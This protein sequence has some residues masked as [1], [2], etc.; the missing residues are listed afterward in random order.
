VFDGLAV[1]VYLFIILDCRVVDYFRHPLPP[2]GFSTAYF[3]PDSIT[4]NRIKRKDGRNPI[5]WSSLPPLLF[6][7]LAPTAEEMKAGNESFL[8]SCLLP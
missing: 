5:T 3:I 7:F 2:H 4:I 1:Y 8:L 6:Q